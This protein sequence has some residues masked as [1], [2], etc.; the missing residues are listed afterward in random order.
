MECC[1]YCKSREIF[2]LQ[3]RSVAC[4]YCTTP[5]GNSP[6]AT[7]CPAATTTSACTARFCSRLCLSRSAQVHPL[8][9][10]SKNPASIP[11]MKFARKTQWMALHALAHCTSRILLA[12]QMDE[13][14]LDECM[15]FVRAL[16]QLGMEERHKYSFNL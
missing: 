4:A 1:I 12:N 10:P 13:K 7:P 16:A 3:M 14:V 6:L 15:E 8:L 9:C 5:F 11:L 2:D